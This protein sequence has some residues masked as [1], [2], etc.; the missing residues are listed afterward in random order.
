M[1]IIMSQTNNKS[2]SAVPQNNNDNTNDP[3]YISIIL[4]STQG[5]RLFPLT[6]EYPNGVPKHLLPI[7][8]LNNNNNNS[9][10]DGSGS[11]RRFE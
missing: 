4:A 11:A 10:E 1:T 2:S 5:A 6:S 8:P 9:G 3:E 7:S